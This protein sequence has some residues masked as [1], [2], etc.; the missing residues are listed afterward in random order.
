M[1]SSGCAGQDGSFMGFVSGLARCKIKN[2]VMRANWLKERGKERCK[3]RRTGYQ[4]PYNES[5]RLISVLATDSLL[6]SS[7]LTRLRT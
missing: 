6:H 3:A 2:G 7:P 4:L 1:C 5:A